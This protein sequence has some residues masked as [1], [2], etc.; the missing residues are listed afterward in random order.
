MHTIQEFFSTNSINKYWKLKLHVSENKKQIEKHN[1]NNND[2]NKLTR[3]KSILEIRS[4]FWN[5]IIS[6]ELIL[7]QIRSIIL[8]F[9]VYDWFLRSRKI[10]IGTS[11]GKVSAL[12]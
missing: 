1:N 8:L 5:D 9:E 12:I 10:L 3:I 2:I 6:G 4:K 7:L 11:L